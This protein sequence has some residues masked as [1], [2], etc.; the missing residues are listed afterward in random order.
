LVVVGAV[1][2]NSHGGTPSGTL[3]PTWGLIQ[4]L[5]GFVSLWDSLATASGTDSITFPHDAANTEGWAVALPSTYSTVLASGSINPSASTVVFHPSAQTTTSISLL[6]VGSQT[7]ACATV[8]GTAW[9]V[10]CANNGYWYDTGTSQNVSAHVAPSIGANS[11]GTIYGAAWVEL[12]A[13]SSCSYAPVGNA[14]ANAEH[15]G[16][17]LSATVTALMGQTA[18][19]MAAAETHGTTSF[20]SLSVSDG[21]SGDTFTQLYATEA[22]VSGDGSG[23]HEWNYSLWVAPMNQGGSHTF[24]LTPTSAG[25]IQASQITV[26]MVSGIVVS[27]G[28][29]VSGMSSSGEPYLLGLGGYSTPDVCVE[30]FGTYDYYNTNGAGGYYG[31]PSGWTLLS[32]DD[33]LT[34]ADGIYDGTYFTPMA[35]SGSQTFNVNIGSSGVGIVGA[36]GF[37]LAQE[38]VVN[39]PVVTAPVLSVV[40]ETVSTV[41]LAWTAPTNVSVVNY[42]VLWGTT[43]GTYT[44]SASEGASTFSVTASSLVSNTTYFF[45]VETWTG[46][47][48]KGPASNVALAHTKDYAPTVPPA[49]C[50]LS[51][52]AQCPPSTGWT[53]DDI[54]LLFVLFFAVL[55]GIGAAVISRKRRK[56]IVRQ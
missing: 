37:Y 47:T 12:T 2:A 6:A 13:P 4:N 42:T 27:A 35:A 7:G 45:V 28:V 50:S 36:Q 16:S 26:F 52:L 8:G 21:A 23:T 5:T 22:L 55:S 20:T 43:Y 54:L 9:V 3:S 40:A 18:V 19:V 32:Q 11:T 29:G 33:A 30:E 53:G 10:S 56:R 44:G 24:T 17:S 34:G 51:N 48:Q 39:P 15:S 49:G 14:G 31:L 1:D 46:A 38:P 25:S 41:G